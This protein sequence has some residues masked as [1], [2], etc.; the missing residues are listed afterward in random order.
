MIPDD[1]H[2]SFPFH[3]FQPQPWTE[4][5]ACKGLPT[6]WWFPGRGDPTD[7]AKQICSTCPVRQDCLEYSFTIPTV[8]GIWGGITGRER[9]KIKSQTS[10]RPKRL[11]NHGTHSGY[12]VHRKRKEQPCEACKEAHALY[13]QTRKQNQ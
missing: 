2:L 5:A 11:I 4:Q 3:L 1:Y 7:Q 10:T 12:V 9:R 13:K 6:E 8:V